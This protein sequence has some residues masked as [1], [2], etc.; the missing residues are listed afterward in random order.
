MTPKARNLFLYKYV[1]TYT[2]M[3][4]WFGGL[5]TLPEPIYRFPDAFLALRL[6]APY[7]IQFPRILDGETEA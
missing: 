7:L 1:H 5:W 4:I 3:C 2:H 6:S